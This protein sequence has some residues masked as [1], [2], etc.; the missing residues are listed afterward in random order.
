MRG[1]TLMPLDSICEEVER[2]VFEGMERWAC[3]GG[4]SEERPAP[5]EMS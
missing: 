1:G 3:A 2:R 5:E 4:Y